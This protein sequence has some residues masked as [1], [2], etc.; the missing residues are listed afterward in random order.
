MTP[1]TTTD[2]PLRT[3]PALRDAAAGDLG[4]IVLPGVVWGASFLFIAEGLKAVG[5]HGVAFSRILAGFVTLLLFPAA[6]GPIARDA[7]PRIALL[8]V[9]WMAIPLTLFPY[10]EQRVST[11]V[12]GM[13][14]GAVPLIATIVAALIA[15]TLPSRGVMVGLAVGLSGVLMVALPNLSAGGASMD[16]VW[17]VLIAI[18]LYG[19]AINVARPLQQ[20]YGALPVLARAL[21]L[22]ALITAPLGVPEVIH[23]H[24]TLGPFLSLLALGSLGTGIAYVLS[25][26]ASGKFG[27][28][29][30][31]AAIF[32]TSPVALL[33][34]VLVLHERIEA[35]SIV[36]AMACIAGALLIRRQD[37]KG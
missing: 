4:L 36:G 35:V 26:V 21:G 11:A 19:I 30:A 24:W 7:W 2:A 18:T 10:A 23:G 3:A 28:T 25:T 29:R 33:L 16:G 32:I 9:F 22:A 8:S 34:G 31:S 12:A 17:L 27:A 14:N 5:P 6:R 13:L 20:K 15:R 37:P 1:A